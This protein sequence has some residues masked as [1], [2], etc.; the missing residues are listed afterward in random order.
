[1]AATLL[2][3]TGAKTLDGMPWGAEYPG[4]SPLGGSWLY[5]AMKGRDRVV[6]IAGPTASGKSALA[7][8]LAKRCGG[9]VVNAD[10]MQVYRELA[11]LT[12]RPNEAETA[13]VPHRLY[14]FCPGDSPC[15]VGKWRALAC[16]E[17]SAASAAGHLPFVVGGSG[18]YLRALEQGLA[19]IPD[20]DPSHRATA[21]ERLA[22]M[23]PAAFHEALAE[24]DPKTAAR[25]RPSDRQRL[26]RA[27]EVIAG[28][29]RGLADW[30][31]AQGAAATQGTHGL[32]YRRLLCLPP[33]EWLYARIDGRL[34]SM[35]T[36][37]ALEEVARLA[38]KGYDS[39]LP[40]MKALGVPHFLA[41]C[42][43]DISLPDALARAQQETRRFAKRQFTWFRHQMPA[44][45]T[46]RLEQPLIPPF[47]ET[48]LKR[49]QAFLLA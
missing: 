17:I 22:R 29:G 48:F 1:V 41:H 20:I 44:R 19:D 8:E 47:E 18:L 42:R 15:S 13:A 14:G 40:V 30:Q 23:G 5:G 45:G 32:T 16:R 4:L 2:S 38:D 33:R 46:L 43:G 37:G 35:L 25:T 7:I 3:G 31:A 28:T 26:I 49:L 34:E 11:V 12:A 39:K 24:V 36:Q 9:I 27:W 21:E 10:S 6:V